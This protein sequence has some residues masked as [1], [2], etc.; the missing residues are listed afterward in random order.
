MP[1]TNGLSKYESATLYAIAYT[2]YRSGKQSICKSTL[3]K[4]SKIGGISED[5]ITRCTNKMDKYLLKSINISD[6]KRYAIYT[7]KNNVPYML[8]NKCAFEKET[9]E[10][11]NWEKIF[12]LGLC[13]LR[14]NGTNKINLDEDKI[15][16]ELDFG[17][18]YYKKFTK[19]LEQLKLIK[20]NKGIEVCVNF[21]HT[22]ESDATVAFLTNWKA[23]ISDMI[24][25]LSSN[26]HTK[27][28]INN[29]MSSELKKYKEAVYNYQNGW[30]G[31]SNPL[32]YLKN[33]RYA[34]V[35]EVHKKRYNNLSYQF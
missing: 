8:I 12:L 1:K 11:S 9:K 22:L 23:D 30:K 35:S 16:K 7:L 28:E 24:S 13:S 5:T 26:K 20:I 34:T 4:L 3:D 27:K 29:I 14:I 21:F 10:L 33:K 2:S 25:Y 19:H 6:K 17:I 32:N 31:I 15:R 18:T